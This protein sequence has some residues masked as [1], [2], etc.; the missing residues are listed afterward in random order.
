LQVAAHPHNNSLVVLVHGIL[1][2][3]Y[4]A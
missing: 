3:R 4:S 2:G 1:S